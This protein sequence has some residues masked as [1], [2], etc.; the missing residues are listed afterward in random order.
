VPPNPRPTSARLH[1]R[2]AACLFA[3]SALGLPTASSAQ[4]PDTPAQTAAETATLIEQLRE[5]ATDPRTRAA[6]ADE[7][8]SRCRT[9]EIARA[10]AELLSD[11]AAP[12]A[13]RDAMLTAIG[14]CWNPPQRLFR[15]LTLLAERPGSLS[16]SALAGAIAAY[17]TREAA[18]VLIRSLSIKAGDGLRLAAAD[19]LVTMTGQDQLGSDFLAWSRWLQSSRGLSESG[20]RDTLAEGV[21]TRQQRIMAERAQLAGKL[22]SGYRRLYLSLPANPGDERARLLAQLISDSTPELRDLGLEVAAR[23]LSAGKVLDGTVADAALGLLR[24]PIPAVRERAAILVTQLGPRDVSAEVGAALAA[25]TDPRAAAALLHAATR[26]PSAQAV[27]PSIS[28]LERTATDPAAPAALLALYQAGFL[29]ITDH[30]DRIA[31]A[32]RRADPWTLSPAACRLLALTG[33]TDDR[34]SLIMLL[35][36][37]DRA[38]RV[39]AAQGLADFPEFVDAILAAARADSALFDAAVE[40]VASHRPTAPSFETL[41]ALPA[42]SDDLRFQ[43]MSLLAAAMPVAELVTVAEAHPEDPAMIE[44]LLAR[45]ADVTVERWPQAGPDDSQGLVEGLMLLARA[46]LDAHRPDRALAALGALPAPLPAE[47]D[48]Q[49]LLVL[50]TIALLWTNQIDQ[51][52]RLGAPISVWLDGLERAAG[53]PHAPAIVARIRAR[54]GPI[55]GDDAARLEAMAARLPQVRSQATP[56]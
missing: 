6:A 42:A 36:A 22:V 38:A 10:I 46:R 29:S 47:A 52:E 53:E 49:Q 56:P 43:G 37:A 50:S 15:S 35:T 19:A 13:A 45:L 7:L 17:R 18:Q 44:L 21:W 9:P 34:A 31:A 14:G 11:E 33:T 2:S 55:N 48:N 27:P 30:G 4:A 28:W 25:E 8:L 3:F 32:L 39:A 12:P 26:W 24:S 16:P 40:S 41:L 54:F 51:A 23:E 1:A 20:W 5:R